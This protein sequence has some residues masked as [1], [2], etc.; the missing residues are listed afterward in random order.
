MYNKNM[1]SAALSL[2]LLTC[3]SR[4]PVRDE[5]GREIPDNDK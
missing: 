2:T 4:L 5:D 3:M 1:K